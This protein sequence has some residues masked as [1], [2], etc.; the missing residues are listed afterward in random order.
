MTYKISFHKEA[1][2]DLYSFDGNIKKYIFKEIDKLKTNPILGKPLGHVAGVNLTGMRKMY[3]YNKKI[4][5]IY[6]VIE[7][8]I[9]VYIISIGKR[10]GLEAYKNAGKRV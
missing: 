9:V 10:E 7:E 6:R 5:I 1:N 4:R 3:A 2:E 8:E